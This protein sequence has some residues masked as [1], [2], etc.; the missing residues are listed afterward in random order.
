[1]EVAL[2]ALPHPLPNHRRAGRRRSP[3]FS[4]AA[5]WGAPGLSQAISSIGNAALVIVAARVLPAGEFGDFTLAYVG[6]LLVSQLVRVALGEASMVWAA[7]SSAVG[8]VAPIVV[9]AALVVTSLIGAAVG[10]LTVWISGSVAFGLAVGVATTLVSLA[11][12]TRYALLAR[13]RIRRAVGFDLTWTLGGLI[14]LLV[15]WSWGTFTPASLL[16]VW[17]LSAAIA[18]V[19]VADVVWPASPRRSLST[20]RRNPHWWRLAANEAMITGSSY[21]LLVVLGIAAATSSVGAVRASLLPYIWVQLA[22]SSTWL[23]VLSRRPSRP[24]LRRFCRAAGTAILSTIAIIAVLVSLTPDSVG[25]RILG[26]QWSEAAALALYAASAYAALSVAELVVL[27]LKA[28]ADTTAVLRA[29]IGGAAVTAL[30]TV[31]IIA[32]S[33]PQMAL[34]GIIAGHAAVAAVGGVSHP[35]GD[36]T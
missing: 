4:R 34:I 6:V 3:G 26:Q 8:D 23:V 11:D 1:M 5:R 12:T 20:V 22:I 19:C 15:L 28:R 29:R 16:I 27:Q 25:R 14:G 36:A 33:S 21:A 31:L 24:Q 9:G 17:A 10:G 2:S 18:V 32:W 7:S 30:A 13:A 35:R